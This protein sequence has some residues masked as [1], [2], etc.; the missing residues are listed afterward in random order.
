MVAGLDGSGE[1][2]GLLL[3]PHVVAHHEDLHRRPGWVSHTERD[4]YW[5]ELAETLRH[6][7]IEAPVM[8]VAGWFDL[9][10]SGTLENHRRVGGPLVIGPWSHLTMGA[11]GT[12]RVDFGFGASAQAIQLEQRQLAFLKGQDTG[13]PRDALDRVHRQRPHRRA[14]VAH[15]RQQRAERRSDVLARLRRVHQPQCRLHRAPVERGAQRERAAVVLQAVVEVV[16]RH[17]GEHGREPR[18]A[19]GRRLEGAA[20]QGSSSAVRCRRTAGRW[21]SR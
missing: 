21:W 6:D 14:L 9:F 3:P 15:D 7:R 2:P 19:G 11:S 12:G 16:R 5:E 4:A 20:G 17:R 10:L 8:H 1:R 18:R 13:P